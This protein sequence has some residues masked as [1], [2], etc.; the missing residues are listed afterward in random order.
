MLLLILLLLSL[1]SFGAYRL[2][3]HLQNGEE[4][5]PPLANAHVHAYTS[6]LVP[7]TCTEWGYTLYTCTDSDCTSAYRDHETE[8]LSHDM[9]VSSSV[10]TKAPDCTH[11]GEE[12]VTSICAR[13]GESETVTASIAAKGHTAGVPVTSIATAPTCVAAGVEITKT[14]CEVCDEELSS[15]TKPLGALGHEDGAPV[16]TRLSSPTCTTAG[17]EVTTVSCL[18]C[19]QEISRTSV[20]L[21]A[22]GHTESVLRTELSAPTCFDEGSYELAVSCTVCQESLGT[23]VHTSAPTGHTFDGRTCTRCHRTESNDG[24]VFTWDASQ[25]GY[26]LVDSGSCTD[27]SVTIDLYQGKPVVGIR[28]D[29]FTYFKPRYVTLGIDITALG[30]A[31]YGNTTLYEISIPGVRVLEGLGGCDSLVSIKDTGSL[32]AV[33]ANACS[34]CRSLKELSL[35]DTVTSIGMGA[36]TYCT[37]LVE[38]A[39]PASLVSIGSRAFY[40]CSALKHLDFPKSLTSIASDAFHLLYL[41]TLTVEDGNPVFHSKDNCLILTDRKVLFYGGAQAVIPS[42]GSV[43]TI[44]TEALAPHRAPLVV[45]EGVTTILSDPFSHVLTEVYLP[46]SITSMASDTFSYCDPLTVY[47]AGS[48]AEWQALGCRIPGGSQ[49]YYHYPAP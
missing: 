22:T 31:F 40:E 28:N 43:T 33:A 12:A 32:T 11:T 44:Y 45:P 5:P 35:P 3:M 27:P 18:R 47:F 36:F 16:T 34:Q 8:P 6:T 46:A 19:Y 39:L 42:D 30:Q 20:S 14:L 26:I 49:I 38:L 13:C 29:A 15:V 41:D 9:Q 23:T 10:L 48:E 1:L 17:E 4:N 7:P 24:L 21:G 25:N 37:S 2:V